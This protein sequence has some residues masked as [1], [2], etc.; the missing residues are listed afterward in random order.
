[1]SRTAHRIYVATLITII[2]VT[3]IV[4]S[5]AGFPYYRTSLEERFFHPH[6]TSL[7]PSGPFGHGLGIIGT[8]MIILGVA[9]YMIR[10][11]SRRLARFGLLKH[12]LEFHIFL[13]TLGPILVLFHTSFKFGGIVS[14]SF[15]SMVAVVLSGVLGRFIYIQIP[16][17][18][19]GRELNLNEVKD[20]QTDIG[21][22]LKEN[23]Q[24]DPDS[25]KVLNDTVA[26]SSTAREGSMVSLMWS[27]MIENRKK[28]RAVKKVI[29]KN[30]ISGKEFRKIVKLIKSEFRLKGRIEKL[31]SMQQLFRYWHIAHL[32]FALI[33][34]IIMVI[35][36]VVTLALGYKWIF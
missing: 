15:W 4:L 10:K 33:M 22:L 5:Y 9:S 2:I 3:I 25:L 35:H 34:L 8:L 12:W 30:E 16:R 11:R 1:M 31:H 36:V 24:L 29:R 26:R 14:V 17:T 20:M 18:I 28:L 32:P 19:Q 27:R 7:K 13:C 21:S 6:H 23:Y